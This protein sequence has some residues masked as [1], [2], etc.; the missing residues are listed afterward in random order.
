MVKEA[1]LVLYS[2]TVVWGG[3]SSNRQGKWCV[4]SQSS[5]RQSH[6]GRMMTIAMQGHQSETGMDENRGGRW[7]SVTRETLSFLDRVP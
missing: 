2:K 5:R 6:A 1:T 4:C 3:G 7:S